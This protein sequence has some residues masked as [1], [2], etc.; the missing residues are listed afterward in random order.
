MSNNLRQISVLYD[1]NKT[2]KCHKGAPTRGPNDT[3]A[4]GGEAKQIHTPSPP[5]NHY[6]K[7]V[8]IIQGSTTVP[9]LFTNLD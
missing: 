1:R 2:V 8:M 4:A 5:R 6:N 7:L 9:R 3:M